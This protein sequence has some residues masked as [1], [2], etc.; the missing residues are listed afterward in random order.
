MTF[1]NGEKNALNSKQLSYKW[2][3]EGWR[4]EVLER[5]T[6]KDFLASQANRA[7][8][9]GKTNG[10]WLT[11]PRAGP[12]SVPGVRGGAQADSSCRHLSV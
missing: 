6:W 9:R 11:E 1:S 8:E 3:F 4:Q 10:L 7:V 2:P 12:L 5:V